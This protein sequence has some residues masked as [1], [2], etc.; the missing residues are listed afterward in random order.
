MSSLEQWLAREYEYA[1]R[2]M[3][4]V[5]SP[6]GII[7]ER[8]G[9]GQTIRP[10]RGA[11]VASPVLA[12]Y[13]PDPDYFFHW[14]RDSAV[15]IDALRVLYED[16]RADA[17]AL[18]DV[19]DFTR[20]SLALQLL[21]GRA[22]VDKPVWR[23]KVSEEFVKF[24]RHELE[25]GAVYGDGVAAETRVNA[26]GSLDISSWTRPQ[27]D[28]APLR[29]LALLRWLASPR[30]R[31]EPAVRVELS[32]MIESDLGFT[33]RHWHES[34]YDMWEEDKGLHYHT[35]C[36]SARALEQGAAWLESNGERGASGA[37]RDE[38]SVIR[39]R[40][41]G[42]WSAQDGFYHSRRLESGASSPKQLD[43][44]VILAAIHAGGRGPH[45]AGDPRA[46]ATLARLESLFDGTYAINRSRAPGTSPAMGRYAGDIYYS[47]GAYYFATLGA[48][49][50]CFRA[51][52]QS[53][54]P[55]AWI[56][57]GDGYL[58]TVRRYTP[59]SG[60]L[61]EQFD[62]NTGAQTSARHLAWSYAALITCVAAR[63]D[64]LGRHP[65]A[66]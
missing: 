42:F 4:V 23:T 3:R 18:E 43:I 14:F 21:D 54:D 12:S 55:Q 25:L 61:S 31:F 65:G 38:A 47:G 35:L 46:Q 24:L 37:Y 41:D 36:V 64:A 63:S 53:P 40:L 33:L 5:I 11:I 44:A 10:V 30:A 28:G 48:A 7:K 9:F 52:A 45:T 57:R 15:I 17:K 51:A 50:F 58:D 8:P 1:A 66:V 29:A 62:Q 56:R 16:G 34:A 32:M 26:D 60:E 27:H 39:E 13:D 22:L 20:F 59:A 49:E 6:I 19:A 2:A